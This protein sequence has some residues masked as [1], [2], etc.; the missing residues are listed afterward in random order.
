MYVWG[1]LALYGGL[2]DDYDQETGSCEYQMASGRGMR[3]VRGIGLGPR[4]DAECNVLYFSV[5]TQLYVSPVYAIALK[6]KVCAMQ[7]MQMLSCIPTQS[8]ILSFQIPLRAMYSLATT[9]TINQCNAM[10]N[11]R[12][13]NARLYCNV[14]DERGSEKVGPRTRQRSRYKPIRQSP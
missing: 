9:T 8:K 4:A 1:G 11:A 2:L 13:Y 14:G 3:G 12:L 6:G 7:I 5:C 10:S